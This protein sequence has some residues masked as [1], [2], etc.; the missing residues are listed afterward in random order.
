MERKNYNLNERSIQVI[1]DTANKKQVS[2]SEALRRII[3]FYEEHNGE[4]K[5]TRRKK[6]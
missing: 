3:E 5:K 2:Q 1:Q 6:Q 4:K